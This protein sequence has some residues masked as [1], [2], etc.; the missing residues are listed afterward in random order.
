MLCARLPK[1]SIGSIK[2]IRAAWEA[3]LIMT[4]LQKISILHKD[5]KASFWMYISIFS[6]FQ[7]T[8]IR[9]ATGIVHVL[10]TQPS[11][12]KNWQT[13][14]PTR[15]MRMTV[16]PAKQ[17]A[18]LFLLP[19]PGPRARSSI[20]NLFLWRLQE[21][22]QLLMVRQHPS[23]SNVEVE[24]S[25][26]VALQKVCALARPDVPG[27][28]SFNHYHLVPFTTVRLVSPVGIKDPF[29]HLG[30]IPS[31]LPVFV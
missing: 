8:R 29:P 25:W 28:P 16:L 20:S 17:K 24:W 4:G 7:S 22:S 27:I 5:R 21:L 6:Y 19:G 23:M 2:A 15:V 14:I 10:G 30:V 13:G 31:A 1:T 26:K 18:H 12:K 3:L 9:P 11:A